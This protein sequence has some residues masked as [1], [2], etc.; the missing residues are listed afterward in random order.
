MTGVGA[1]DRS[2]LPA[3]IRTGSEQQRQ[4]YT[5]ALGFER[6]LVEQL[7]KQLTAS[8]RIAGDEDDQESAAT[9]TY[10]DLM[11]GALAD[12]VTSAGGLGLAAQ[13][14]ASITSTGDSPA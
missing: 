12:A 2:L 7:A 1:I 3:E 5:A 8:A 4:A 13:I 6:Q 10:R 11:P 14:A 9:K